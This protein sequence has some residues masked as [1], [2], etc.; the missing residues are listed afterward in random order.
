MVGNLEKKT[1]N[2]DS[3]CS[4]DNRVLIVFLT[5]KDK[6]ETI[7]SITYNGDSLTYIG[8]VQTIYGAQVNAYYLI[9]PDTGEN[10]ISVSHSSAMSLGYAVSLVGADQ[11]S[12]IGGKKSGTDTSDPWSI[13]YS[14]TTTVDNSIIL[15]CATTNNVSST[16]IT[17]GA[18]QTKLEERVSSSVYTNSGLSK[19]ETTSAGNYT[20]TFNCPSNCAAY[21]VEVKGIAE[22]TRRRAAFISFF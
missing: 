10:E 14:I 3:E 15:G 5:F 8:T 1:Q 12:P 6:N 17:Y 22:E 2:N 4:G 9:N 13:S 7:S 16:S 18:N 20:E 19:Q 21:S 11:S